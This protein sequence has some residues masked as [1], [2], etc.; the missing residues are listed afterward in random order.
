MV[1]MWRIGLLWA[2]RVQ[3]PLKIFGGI[4]HAAPASTE[5]PSA[6]RFSG[7][8]SAQNAPNPRPVVQRSPHWRPAAPAPSR[9]TG[10]PHLSYHLELGSRL[11]AVAT[12][13]AAL[14]R[15]PAPA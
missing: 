2:V 3:Y 14:S 8:L 5:T 10:N 7:R 1:F 6:P 12:W 13:S 9:T 4:A 11:P 15:C